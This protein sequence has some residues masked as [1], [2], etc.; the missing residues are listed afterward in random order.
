MNNSVEVLEQL[1]VLG[2]SRSFYCDVSLIR[3][4]SG[5][6]MIC[7][8]MRDKEKNR[9]CKYISLFPDQVMELRKILNE[10]EID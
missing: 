7:I 1:G 8:A 9:Q 2:E 10:L 4:K 5:H 6:E 3:N